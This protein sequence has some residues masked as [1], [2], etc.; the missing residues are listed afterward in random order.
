MTG[1][2]LNRSFFEH[3][4]P[5]AAAVRESEGKMAIDTP[6]MSNSCAILADY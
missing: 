1:I 2:E 4:A 3:C 6:I 5:S